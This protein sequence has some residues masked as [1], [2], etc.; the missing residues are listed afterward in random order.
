M[1]T[2]YTVT[3]TQ[4]QFVH[5]V[6]LVIERLRSRRKAQCHTTSHHSLKHF[7]QQELVEE[8]YGAYKNL[9][10][11]M[12]LRIPS[13]TDL[14]HIAD[15]LECSIHE[16]NELLL[17]AQYLPEYIDI[18]EDWQQAAIQHAVRLLQQLPFPMF[19]STYTEGLDVLNG[20]HSCVAENAKRR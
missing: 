17:T 8:V 1:S 19:I 16:T 14:L 12:T 10:L 5:A 6:V 2:V 15:Y 3:D 20:E 11:G 7:T 13:R 4:R 18:Q 9:V